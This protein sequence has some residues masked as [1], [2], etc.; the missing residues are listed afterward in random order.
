MWSYAYII[1]QL[2][3]V[4][5]SNLDATYIGSLPAFGDLADVIVQLQTDDSLVIQCYAIMTNACGCT[6][7][8]QTKYKTD[9][10]IL[11]INKANVSFIK[12]KRIKPKQNIQ[13]YKKHTHYNILNM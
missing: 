13:K 12:R 3:I 2:P 10:D 4:D 7:L 5:V 8:P 1:R 11:D 6:F 9:P